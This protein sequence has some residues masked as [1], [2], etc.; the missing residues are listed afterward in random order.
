MWFSGGANGTNQSPEP[1]PIEQWAPS[2]ELTDAIIYALGV[3]FVIGIPL[4]IIG[5]II[6]VPMYFAY[7]N[8]QNGGVVFP[9]IMLELVPSAL[10]FAI[11]GVALLLIM[12]HVFWR[13]CWW[14]LY[15]SALGYNVVQLVKTGEIPVVEIA[16]AFYQ[17]FSQ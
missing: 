11:I 4:A 13:I 17:Y 6:G 7:E 16:M 12:Q 15:L 8:L 14:G 10:L 1:Q 3:F 5:A 2:K 9:F